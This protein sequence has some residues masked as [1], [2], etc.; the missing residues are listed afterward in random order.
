[1]RHLS[2]L[3][4]LKNIEKGYG[5]KGVFSLGVYLDSKTGYTLYKNELEKPYFVDKTRLLEE[6][7][8]MICEG[9]NYICITRPRRFGKTVIA[10][11]IAAFFSRSCEAKDI[12]ERLYIS[13]VKNYKQYIN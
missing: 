7:I 5:R 4:I 2:F 10:N 9:S 11:M 13:S 8:P 12:F 1:M 6:L 3:C